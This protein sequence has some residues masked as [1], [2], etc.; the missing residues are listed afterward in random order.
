MKKKI[1]LVSLLIV[2]LTM[3][4]V[5]L[6]GCKKANESSN[7]EENSKIDNQETNSKEEET[8]GFTID[9]KKY[10]LTE[11]REFHNL[12]FKY[13]KDGKFITEEE[14]H[15][16]LALYQDDNEEKILAKVVITFKQD[17]NVEEYIKYMREVDASTLNTAT[18]NGT[19]WYKYDYLGE[20]D[21][22]QA[23]YGQNGQNTYIISFAQE[24]EFKEVD[25]EDLKATF[26]NN[27]RFE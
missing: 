6:S 17:K 7:Q 24:G 12:K 14:N 2:I 1:V 18:F 20:R 11:E 9:G 10:D 25:I 26:M 3:G 4:L 21:K 19:K 22:A 27:T 8:I 16:V 5:T 13:P 23:H 15:I